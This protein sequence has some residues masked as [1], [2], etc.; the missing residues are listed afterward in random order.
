VMLVYFMG[1]LSVLHVFRRL[2]PRAYQWHLLQSAVVYA[3]AL[4]TVSVTLAAILV[5]NQ[6][7]RMR[8]EQALLFGSFAGGCLTI[9]MQQV[10]ASFL[11]HL[12]VH[13]VQL[14]A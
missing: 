4:L 1:T 14:D 11:V 13:R 12:G 3:E 5:L 6:P 2:A 8:R 10:V 7:L 9:L